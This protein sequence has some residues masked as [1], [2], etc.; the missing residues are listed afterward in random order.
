MRHLSPPCLPQEGLSG[1]LSRT[2]K[3]AEC[4]QHTVFIRNSVT[5]GVFRNINRYTF[6]SSLSIHL[7][8]C[9]KWPYIFFVL[10]RSQWPLWISQF[11]AITRPL[12]PPL[13][14]WGNSHLK[15]TRVLVGNFKKNLYDV[16]GP[17]SV[18]VAWNFIHHWRVIR[19]KIIRA[20]FLQYEYSL[21]ITFLFFSCINHFFL[22]PSLSRKI[23]WE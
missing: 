2:N 6:R 4:K 23:N 7:M 5:N 17:C 14:K 11:Y 22:I 1:P 16:P 18:G 8:V 12:C 9:L 13:P 21:A 10:S 20:N 3:G 15:R 19:V